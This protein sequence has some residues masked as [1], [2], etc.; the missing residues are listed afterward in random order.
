M[1]VRPHWTVPSE[2]APT[3]EAAVALSPHGAVIDILA[4]HHE[5]LDI[6]SLSQP[7]EIEGPPDQ[8]ASLVVERGV[9][10]APASGR[11]VLRG[12]SLHSTCAPAL[13]VA[14]PC[15]VEFCHISSV[16]IGVQ[17]SASPRSGGDDVPYLGQNTIT[18]CDVG[19]CIRGDC[20]AVL[21]Q[22]RLEGNTRGVIVVGLELPEGDCDG[23]AVLGR[24]SFASSLTAD[25][26]LV[27]LS[28]REAGC[29][30]A[31]G[32]FLH[33]V[34]EDSGVFLTR[35]GHARSLAVETD[36]G[37]NLVLR[38]FDEAK[39]SAGFSGSCAAFLAEGS[40]A[41]PGEGL[42][43]LGLLPRRG[44][45][46][47]GPLPVEG[48]AL[49]ERRRDFA[50]LVAPGGQ[51]SFLVVAPDDGPPAAWARLAQSSGAA[52]FGTEA[53]DA[54]VAELDAWLGAALGGTAPSGLVDRC[55]ALL[56]AGEGVAL[57]M[58]YGLTPTLLQ[59]H[60]LLA[61]SPSAQV[62]VAWF[63]YATDEV[64][65]DM[66]VCG[67]DLSRR[68]LVRMLS[69]DLNGEAAAEEASAGA[70]LRFQASRSEE[71]EIAQ[72]VARSTGVLRRAV[73]GG[74]WD[75]ILAIA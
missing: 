21:D 14:G 53:A 43:G 40:G 70:W 12:L 41:C 57:T 7:F 20:D 18:G 67:G 1:E 54:A 44:R 55:V 22:N 75:E 42:T 64:R 63:V 58:H 74:A 11:V 9:L 45:W 27:S 56:G 73:D 66:S 50:R 32:G 69:S 16:S 4:G 36:R 23:L 3:L 62:R 2:A 8:S 59:P 5:E 13:T 37:G 30:E 71:R 24:T 61:V 26:Q 29:I 19:L 47:T 49:R 25:V 60:F 68:R 52:G 10:C 28:V 6:L 35:F 17:L 31:G 72:L 65:P 46:R 38:F 48:R 51:C 33:R 39:V 34:V 15:T